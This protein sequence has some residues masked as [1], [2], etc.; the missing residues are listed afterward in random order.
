MNNQEINNLAEIAE[1]V[2]STNTIRKGKLLRQT[3]DSTMASLILT[4]LRFGMSQAESDKKNTID[5]F[6]ALSKS[7]IDIK[8]TKD[9]ILSHKSI[10]FG[11]NPVVY[12]ILESELNLIARQDI[13]KEQTIKIFES[14]I[15]ESNHELTIQTE[16]LHQFR[17]IKCVYTKYDEDKNKC[18]ERSLLLKNTEVSLRK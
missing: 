4:G 1:S 10:A 8:Q 2:I 16:M 7:P 9:L 5:F 14:N 11:C 15:K 18:L 17:Q 6:K 13:I 3:L 12:H